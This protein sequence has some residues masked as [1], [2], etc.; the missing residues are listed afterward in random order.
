MIENQRTISEWADKTFGY[1]TRERSIARMIE[2]VDELKRIEITDDISNFIKMADEC[3]DIYITMCQ[4]A[5]TFGFDLHVYI[6]Y[7]MD[8]NRH[9]KWKRMGDGTGQHIKE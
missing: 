6:D 5:N 9:R 1:P 2:E 7:K 8:I 4:I 3:A